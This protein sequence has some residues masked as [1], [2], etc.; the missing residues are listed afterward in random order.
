MRAESQFGVR[1]PNSLAGFER[2]SWAMSV[3]T[4]AGGQALDRPL[5]LANDSMASHLVRF[6]GFYHARQSGARRRHAGLNYSIR[7]L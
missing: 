2:H 3:H 7:T 5:R 4:T 6:S 1:I